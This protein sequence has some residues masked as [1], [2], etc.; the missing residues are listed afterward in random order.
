M[1]SLIF[2]TSC[3][4]VLVVGSQ[5]NAVQTESDD[6]F[7]RSSQLK[8]RDPF[9]V[10]PSDTE[11][12]ERKAAAEEEAK[13]LA[14]IA[15]MDKQLLLEKVR[16]LK[17]ES[18]ARLTEIMNRYQESKNDVRHLQQQVQVLQNKVN[19]ATARSQ[20]HDQLLAN[21]LMPQLVSEDEKQQE[22]GLRHLEEIVV[23]VEGEGQHYYPN[24]E[25]LLRQLCHLVDSEH[26]PVRKKAVWLVRVMSPNTAAELG[27]QNRKDRW[28]SVNETRSSSRVSRSLDSVCTLDYES[29]VLLDVIEEIQDQYAINVMLDNSVD[30]EMLISIDR[31]G[32]SLREGLTQL[33]GSK[34]LSFRV[35]SSGIAVS[36]QGDA[37][38]SHPKTYNIRGLLTEEIGVDEIVKFADQAF[39]KAGSAQKLDRNR[40]VV[41]GDEVQHERV[42]KALAAI[43]K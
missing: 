5:C 4:L 6:P 8:Q 14:E 31:R 27:F 42:A 18:D 26:E 7:G 16:R 21:F 30:Q 32:V 23:T 19:V 24:S 37:S 36:K 43:A 9:S 22:Q 34:G 13:Q 39:G 28:V 20:V 25:R 41:I 3:M 33:L 15:K 12:A 40:F 11:E 35:S 38:L 10:K 29:T 17:A 1:R 2:L